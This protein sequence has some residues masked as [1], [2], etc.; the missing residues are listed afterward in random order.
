LFEALPG[1]PALKPVDDLLLDGRYVE[2]SRRV[3]AYLKRNP[4]DIEAL[5]RLAQCWDHLGKPAQALEAARA[6][7]QVQPDHLGALCMAANALEELGRPREALPMVERAIRIYD[8]LP[9]GE[10]RSRRPAVSRNYLFRIQWRALR[11]VDEL[12]TAL[13]TARQGM[14][15]DRAM[16]WHV[17]RSLVE[18]GRFEEAEHLAGPEPTPREYAQALWDVACTLVDEERYAEALPY[19]L[20]NLAFAILPHDFSALQAYLECL[21]CAGRNEEL[22]RLCLHWLQRGRIR[23]RPHRRRLQ[24]MLAFAYQ[25]LGQFDRARESVLE[26]CEGRTPDRCFRLFR[27]RNEFEVTGAAIRRLLDEVLGSGDPAD[28]G[29]AAPDEAGSTQ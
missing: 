3:E 15:M 9:F 11:A 24:V 28:T 19:L 17:L 12:E 5:Y 8:A 10:Q 29:K 21:A 25:G 2:A 4:H 14:Q 6:A 16:E 22:G 26:L 18:L 1:W 20:R 27:G 13:E 23:W 7:L